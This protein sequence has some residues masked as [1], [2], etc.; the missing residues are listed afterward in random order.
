MEGDQPRRGR[1]ELP[2]RCG[3]ESGRGQ[4]RSRE[5]DRSRD[6]RHSRD[7]ARQWNGSREIRYIA[8]VPDQDRFRVSRQGERERRHAETRSHRRP[9]RQLQ[10]NNAPIQQ[11]IPV[12][13]QAPFQFQVP[14]QLPIQQQVALHPGQLHV[15]V[16]YQV[17][18][19]PQLPFQSQPPVQAQLPVHQQLHVHQPISKICPISGY[20][21]G[22]SDSY[23][24]QCPYRIIRCKACG[25][26]VAAEWKFCAMCFQPIQ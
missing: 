11:Q 26:I 20:P 19:Q 6:R 23:C 1:D 13:P 16:Q 9:S 2:D 22:P 24:S 3:G 14:I 8:P 18:V 12:Q 7:R 25:H 5:R 4:E 10:V 15:P 21:I 17:P